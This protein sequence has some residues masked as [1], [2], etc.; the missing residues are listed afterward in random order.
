MAMKLWLAVSTAIVLAFLAA[1]QGVRG[2]EAGGQI[3]AQASTAGFDRAAAV[4]KIEAALKEQDDFR[5][6]SYRL[7]KRGL[8][9]EDVK[10]E[11]E[12]LK[13]PEDVPGLKDDA[14]RVVK[15]DPTDEAALKAMRVVLMSQ[16]EG[17]APEEHGKLRAQLRQILFAHH[18]QRSY[19][20]Q[21]APMV[22][23]EPAEALEFWQRVYAASTNPD[24]RG[25]AAGM[26]MEH[27]F[28]QLND[29][30]LSDP[31]RKEIRGKGMGYAQEIK[32]KYAGVRVGPALRL[33]RYMDSQS[34]TL[35]EFVRNRETILAHS[36]GER[37]PS[38]KVAD[39]NG[40]ID[41]LGKYRGKV[42]LVDFWA[43]W[44]GPCKAGHPDLVALDKEMDG[45]PFQIIGISVDD[46]PADVVKYMKEKL[47]LPW[48]QWH[49]GPTGKLLEEWGVQGFPTYLVV[50]P[51]GIVRERTNHLDEE[52][53]AVIRK[54]VQ[55]LE[56]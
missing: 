33:P 48:V 25:N 36:V 49:I 41:E 38:I 50:G 46:K 56:G 10:A 3:W 20:L 16:Y 43:T 37:L 30:S 34:A 8:K 18:L 2:D 55:Q 6:E 51:D 14:L 47:D 54:L 28:T 44:C 19:F 29:A 23:P 4:E 7:W 22:Q 26:L 32:D 53:K 39:L 24:V 11:R 27:Y 31:V 52:S 15:A 5:D 13:R 35:G 12:A 45:R 1:P 9:G 40:A 21:V 42:L 17:F